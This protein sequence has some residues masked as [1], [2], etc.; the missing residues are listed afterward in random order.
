MGGSPFD[1]ESERLEDVYGKRSY[2]VD[3]EYSDLNPV[4]LHRVQAIER[5]TLAALRRSGHGD[6]LPE[7]RVLDYGCGNGRWLGRWLAWGVA[8]ERL[9]GADVR[10]SAVAAARHNVPGVEVATMSD[11]RV[12]AADAGFD[13]VSATLVFS[14]ILSDEIRAAAAADMTRLLRPGGLLVVCDFR[15]DNPRNPDVRAL[16]ST[17][18][19]TLFPGLEPVSRRKVVLAPPIARRVVP[20]SWT[21]ANLLETWFPVLRTHA[22]VALRRPQG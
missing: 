14:S 11:G 1:G 21:A 5:E 18:L 17:E 13:I 4:Y 20:R 10:P 15:F 8:G 3:P 6:R 19:A 2:D 16:T 22:V 7:L 9:V 12:A